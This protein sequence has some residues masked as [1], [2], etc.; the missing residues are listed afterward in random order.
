MFR[1][2]TIQSISAAGVQGVI[3]DG[4]LVIDVRTPKEWQAGHLPFAR[5]IPLE[6]LRTRIGE[7]DSGRLTVFVCRSGA[8]SESAAEAL[9]PHGYAVANLTGGMTA[10]RRAGLPVVREDGSPGVVI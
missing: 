7:L 8:R 9:E 6:D 4:A 10:C 3:V 1:R 5:H 2:T